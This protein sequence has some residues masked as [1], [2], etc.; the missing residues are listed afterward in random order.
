MNRIDVNVITVGPE[1]P[2]DLA[3]V[4][5]AIDLARLILSQV[6][7]ILNEVQF[8]FVPLSDSRGR[9]NIDSDAEA[10]A[11][12]S[13]WT[14][15]NNALDMFFV[16]TYAGIPLGS[17]PI[18]GGPCDKNAFGMTGSVVAIEGIPTA[19]GQ[20]TAHEIGH[21]LGLNHEGDPGNLMF[22][23]VPNLARLRVDQGN[24]MKTHCFVF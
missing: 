3:E 1:T 4:S 23:S 13:E 21:Y 10:V 17:S 8:F 11:L 7:L 20:A 19:T 24:R 22:Q 6:G 2:P 5:G 9:E 18:G 15:P 12:T 16:L 14:V